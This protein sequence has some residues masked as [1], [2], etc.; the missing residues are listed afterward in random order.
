MI[1]V[2][3]A[4][5]SQSVTR[6]IGVTQFIYVS[7]TAQESLNQMNA[8]LVLCQ[9]TSIKMAKSVLSLDLVHSHTKL[10]TRQQ[11]QV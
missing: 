5:R 9:D 3:H 10:S 11:E 8:K 4:L 2:K 6:V 1:R 7:Q